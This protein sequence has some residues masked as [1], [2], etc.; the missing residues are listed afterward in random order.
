MRGRGP[1]LVHDKTIAGPVP[2]P[3]TYR[4]TSTPSFFPPTLPTK[5][6]TLSGSVARVC[7][8]TSPVREFL[9]A[10]PSPATSIEGGA[11]MSVVERRPNRDAMQN[12]PVERARRA[13]LA[14]QREDGSWESWN[15]GG[16]IVT[17]QVI[18][19]L[20]FV[21][22]LAPRDATDAARW[23]AAQ[24]RTDGSFEAYPGSGSGDLSATAV[25]WAALRVAGFDDAEPVR[26][27][28]R[29]LT[30]NGGRDKV[31]ERLRQGDSAAV[32]LALASLLNPEK[33]AR[34]PLWTLLE[35]RL[36]GVALAQL[37]QPGMLARCLR[38]ESGITPEGEA[39][40]RRGLAF[41]DAH[42]NKD[43]SWGE[44]GAPSSALAMAAVHAV[45][46]PGSS[47]RIER[48]IDAIQRLAV[49]DED[50]L[51]YHAQ[52]SDVWTTA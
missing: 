39:T 7:S 37:L 26:R 24:Q 15:V 31:G 22:R 1:V 32:F 43:G 45:G 27:A 48:G 47:S 19:A 9:R 14:G 10:V 41:L 2:P 11:M 30:D 6:T 29:F 4:L 52:C 35:D 17:G 18:L 33:L 21:G 38:G 8:N 42:Q 51:R 40:A 34:P 28:R 49:R 50:G 16:P 12:D 36:S 46:L 25:V 5:R 3:V 13:I 20:N 44:G 23:L